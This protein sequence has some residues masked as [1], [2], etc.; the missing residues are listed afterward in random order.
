M[1]GRGG[2]RWV[3]GLGPALV[4]IDTGEL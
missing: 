3:V 1:I 2:W 4:L